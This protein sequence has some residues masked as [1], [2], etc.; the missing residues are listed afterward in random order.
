MFVPGFPDEITLSQGLLKLL[1]SAGNS[2]HHLKS[3]I[4]FLKVKIRFLPDFHQRN[5]TLLTHRS[6]FH[7]P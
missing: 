7:E 4:N 3:G 2:T 1:Y 6:S 5:G